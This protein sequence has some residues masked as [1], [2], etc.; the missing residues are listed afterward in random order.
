VAVKIRH[1]AMSD[2]LG[3]REPPLAVLMR[4][5][6]AWA[7]LEARAVDPKGYLDSVEANLWR[8]LSDFSRTAFEKGSGSELKH[9]MRALHSSSALAVNFFDYWTTAEPTTLM[10]LLEFDSPVSAIRFEAQH[11]TG[12][13]GIPPN[14]DVCLVLESGHTVAIE[15]KFTEWLTRKRFRDDPF[16]AKYFPPGQELWT[17]RGLSNVSSW[18]VTCRTG[19]NVSCISMR[20]RCS[21]THSASQLS[22]VA[23]FPFGMFIST[24]N[25]QSPI[26][27]KRKSGN[28]QIV[29]APRFASRF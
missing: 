7:T 2:E 5:Q 24:A 17:S 9:K 4:K 1:F 27:I 18:R 26:F 14:L 22:W 21:S 3:R 12:L 29:S 13:Q 6:R 28:S 11:P 23:S 16:K 25:A 20:R 15:S 19:V 8:S 10:H